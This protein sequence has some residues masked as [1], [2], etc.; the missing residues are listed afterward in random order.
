MCLNE[1]CS[2]CGVGEHLC[3]VFPIKKCLIEEHRL[4]V[5]ENDA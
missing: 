5:F 2:R 3:Y 4:R 1:T